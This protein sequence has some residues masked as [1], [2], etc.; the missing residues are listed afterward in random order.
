[1]AETDN[2][3]KRLV[4]FAITDFAEWLLETQVRHIRTAE[5]RVIN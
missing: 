5:H 2:P 4:R 1:M 3:L